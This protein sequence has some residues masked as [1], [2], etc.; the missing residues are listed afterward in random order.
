M[1]IAHKST[2]S[3]YF[4]PCNNSGERYKGVPQKVE[5]SYYF[6]FTAHPKS[7]SLTFPLMNNY[8]RERAR[9]FK[10]L[11]LDEVSYSYASN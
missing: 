9:Y 10:V 5:R 11:Y 2:F 3:S 1:P 8:L 7:H 4:S 6:L